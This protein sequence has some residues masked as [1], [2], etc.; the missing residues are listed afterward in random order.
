MDAGSILIGVRRGVYSIAVYTAIPFLTL[1]GSNPGNHFPWGRL[2]LYWLVVAGIASLPVVLVARKGRDVAAR[3]AAILAVGLFSFGQFS[4]D[5]AAALDIRK[6]AGLSGTLW[7]FAGTVVAIVLASRWKATQSLVAIFGTLLLVAGIL[8]SFGEVSLTPTPSARAE[9]ATEWN[10]EPRDRPNVYWFILDGYGRRDVLETYYGDVSQREFENALTDR[11]FSI[12]SKAFAAYPMTYLSVASTLSADYLVTEKDSVHDQNAFFR[13]AQS[14]GPVVKTFEA[15][16]YSYLLWPGDGF[17]GTDCVG[18]EDVCLRP[19]SWVSE[20][21][22]ALLRMTP[23]S[24]LIELTGAEEHFARSDPLAVTEALQ[25]LD[26][27]GPTLTLV[28]LINPHPPHYE[29]GPD[30]QFQHVPFRLGAVYGVSEY[31]GAVHCL[32]TR[33][34]EA[35]DRILDRDETAV[36]ILQGDHGPSWSLAIHTDP[37]D[38]WN[39][40]ETHIRLGVLSAMRLPASCTMPDVMSLPNTF[41]ILLDCLSRDRVPLLEDRMW[42]GNQTP[43]IL[44]EADPID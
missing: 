40:R 22:R 14:G 42:I 12:A 2:L 3:L 43:G 5:V 13:I 35:V 36:I 17:P 29:T 15:W 26:V 11:G 16:G 8:Q 4:N 38:R 30:C 1:I 44:R 25:A 7:V 18:L 31:V 27:S 9:T 33:L 24:S 10:I 6:I 41:R 21:E 37:L 20:P 39:Q 32:N 28:H 34:L 19:S 23:I